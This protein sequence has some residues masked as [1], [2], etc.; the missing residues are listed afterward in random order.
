MLGRASQDDWATSP[1]QSY[2]DSTRCRFTSD[3]RSFVPSLRKSS[4]AT[5][6]SSCTSRSPCQSPIPTPLENQNHEP[7][8]RCQANAICV[9]ALVPSGGLSL[10]GTRWVASRY[11]KFLVPVKVLSAP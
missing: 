7:N 10:D 2:I 8:A 5:T 9:H 11:P 3:R 1:Q 6:S 4:F